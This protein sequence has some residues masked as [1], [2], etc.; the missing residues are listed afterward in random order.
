MNQHL[1]GHVRQDTQCMMNCKPLNFNM[2]CPPGK[3]LLTSAHPVCVCVP[4]CVSV[5]ES[6]KCFASSLFTC[7]IPH[8]RLCM[9]NRFECVGVIYPNHHLA[10]S[11]L[12]KCAFVIWVDGRMT[13]QVRSM[14]R[15]RARESNGIRPAKSVSTSPS[16]TTDGG[17]PASLSTFQF[18]YIPFGTKSTESRIWY[19]CKCTQYAYI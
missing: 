14:M 11:S 15:F 17:F 18:I 19:I 16:E 12:I 13:V 7:V 9:W 3:W 5:R 10:L 2:R 6:L 8:V 4:V 1:L